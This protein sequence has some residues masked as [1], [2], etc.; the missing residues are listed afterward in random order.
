MVCGSCSAGGCSHRFH[1]PARRS[2][3]KGGAARRRITYKSSTCCRC[4]SC[5][6]GWCG[7]R[8][9]QR[10][11]RSWAKNG[12]TWLRITYESS[13]SCACACPR[14]T[15]Y[16]QTP[17]CCS[18]SA[19]DLH[20]TAW[21]R[22]TYTSVM[23]GCLRPWRALHIWVA[24]RFCQPFISQTPHDRETI[25]ITHGLAATCPAPLGNNRNAQETVG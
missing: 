11:R 24:C 25:C 22:I 21:L 12:T 16:V 2:W 7:H 23:A 19:L 18:C 17:H 10:V 3:A 1:Q 5:S 8:F 9:R 6:V 14:D 4:V 20:A 13:T 15:W